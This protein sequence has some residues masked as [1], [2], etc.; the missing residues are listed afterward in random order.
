MSFPFAF[1]Q[2]PFAATPNVVAGGSSVIGAA[3]FLVDIQVAASGVQAASGAALVTIDLQID[4]H[5]VSPRI[6]TADFKVPF[7]FLSNNIG[8]ADMVIPLLL[9]AVG[10]STVFGTAN[11]PV[12]FS[13]ATD[14]LAKVT[15][16]ATP[17]VQ[18]SIAATGMA[19]MV[20][21]AEISIPLEVSAEGDTL[22]S[23]VSAS[24]VAIVT[25][26]LGTHFQPAVL[27]VEVSAFGSRG[28]RCTGNA[29]VS[30]IAAAYGA[31]GVGGI[32]TVSLPIVCTAEGFHSDR[33]S[34]ETE[35]S[36][37]FFV[38][39]FGE[40]HETVHGV[41]S[42]EP[43]IRVA[44]YGVTKVMAPRQGVFVAG[45]S[46]RVTARAVINAGYAH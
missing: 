37:P 7:Y 45:K 8:V 17:V 40:N 2:T 34:G 32:A 21:S 13:F 28:V 3:G 26:A 36:V 42:I 24:H 35:F 14:G 38:E 10:W 6:G 30:V 15:G 29:E 25:E 18:V 41:I 27:Q 12:Q 4:A 39:A 43:M 22:V 23:G 5:I 33:C 16:S 1:S 19:A 20:G 11:V 31:A 46:N 44:A 9:N